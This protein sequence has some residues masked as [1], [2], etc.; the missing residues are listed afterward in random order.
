MEPVDRVLQHADERF[1]AG[2]HA[3]AEALCQEALSRAPGH[4]DALRLLG[5]LR[6]QGG[7]AADAIPLL[8]EA[9]RAG[10]DSLSA[11]DGLSA[12]LI[13]V[14]DHS[15]AE[16]LV[17]RALA[18]NPD[19]PAAHMRLGMALAFQGKWEA[20]ARAFA[21][22]AARDPQ[23]ADAHHNLGDALTKLNRVPEAIACFRRALAL[24]PA[25]PDSHNSLGYALQ[26]MQ[27]GEAAIAR[28]RRALELNPAFAMAH[29]NLGIA[30]LFRHEFDLGWP[31]YER[32]LACAPIRAGARQ[33]PATVD[34]YERLPRWRGPGEAG[35][36]EVAIWGEQ[37]IGDQVLFSTLIP[38]L[39][40]SG[41]AFVYE[42]DRR[43][44]GAYQRAFPAAHFVPL[45]DPPHE[46]LQRAERVLL[47]GSLP[48]LFR[49]SRDDFARQ[50]ARLL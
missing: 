23:L 40:E 38:D 36:G 50:P 25:N 16:A 24:N 21:E 34:L 49:R 20:A 19:L 32:R 41:T 3:R 33:D 37:G 15:R 30:G 39:I 47:A 14:G 12:A 10:P 29:Y 28:Y 27:L 22:A 48:G 44:L 11:L 9:L 31:G 6:L 43:L 2:D 45:A 7:R 42:V 1:N 26:E 35:A 8:S 5:L 18:V 13:A 17:R 46:A 4:P